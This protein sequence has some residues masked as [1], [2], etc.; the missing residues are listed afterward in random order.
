MEQ[1]ASLPSNG[2]FPH[3]SFLLKRAACPAGNG[4][5]RHCRSR[6]ARPP[7]QPGRYPKMGTRGLLRA[8]TLPASF[9]VHRFRASV[10]STLR[11]RE[12]VDA[13]AEAPIQVHFGQQA[14]QDRFD[15][16]RPEPS[17]RVQVA[18]TRPPP[19]VSGKDPP[20]GIACP[21][22]PYLPSRRRSTDSR[23][24]RDPPNGLLQR[25]HQARAL[26]IPIP[27][28]RGSWPAPLP[29]PLSKKTP[30]LPGFLALPA[31]LLD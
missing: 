28:A 13:F 26:Q 21:A 10:C 2:P 19:E 8:Q 7:T 22:F 30:H 18:Y 23:S 14:Q 1:A 4:R 24:I 12:P 3:Q 25:D 6:Q 29:L 17:D 9:A 27:L 5:S 11:S 31:I 20:P 15:P 16:E